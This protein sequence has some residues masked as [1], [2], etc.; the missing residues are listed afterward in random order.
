MAAVAMAPSDPTSIG[1]VVD[2]CLFETVSLDPAPAPVRIELSADTRALVHRI[3]KGSELGALVIMAAAI[4]WLAHRYSGRRTVPLEIPRAVADPE[5]RSTASG[6]V[7]I[8]L[9]IAGL[10]HLGDLLAELQRRIAGAHR[11][12]SADSPGAS[13]LLVMPASMSDHVQASPRHDLCICVELGA[14]ELHAPRGRIPRWFLVDVGERMAEWIGLLADLRRPLDVGDELM[15]RRSLAQIDGFNQT[16]RPLPVG[17]TVL[18]VLALRT[19]ST[20]EAIA[21]RCGARSLSY[22]QLERRARALATRL[23]AQLGVIP[24][25]VVAALDTRSESAIVSLLGI[26]AAGAVYLPV[27]RKTPAASMQRM[28]EESGAVGLVVHAE[29]LEL[30]RERLAVHPHLIVDGPPDETMA[31]APYSPPSP[32]PEDPAYII[33]TSGTTG[34]AKGVRLTHVGLLNTALDHVDRLRV[35]ADDRYLQFMAL[36]FDGF[37]LDVFTTL[38]AGATLVIADDATI[39]DPSRLMRTIEEQ[40]ITLSTI[41]PSYLQLLEPARLSSLRALVSAGEVLGEELARSLAPRL[42]LY[43]GYGPTEATI[44]ATLQ[45]V[46]PERCTPPI[47][48]GRPSANKQIYVVDERLE[49]QPL[50]VVGELCIAGIGVADGYLGEPRPGEAKFVDNPFGAGRLYR[51]GDF[52]AWAP[53][54]GLLFKGRVDS[55]L[56]L[57]GYRIDRREIQAA[58]A[59]H[60]GV[61]SVE[62]VVH[63]PGSPRATLLAFYQPRGPERVEPEALREHLRRVLP[64]YMQPHHLVASEPWP[65]TPHGKTDV[66]ALHE[67]W[68]L[69]AARVATDHVPPSTATERILCEIWGEVLGVSEPGVTASFLALGGDSIRLIQ[70]VHRARERGL[71]LDVG[72]VLREPTIAGLA[73]HLD[74]SARTPVDLQQ[75]HDHLPLGLLELAPAERAVLPPGI[76]DAY[77]AALMQSFMIETYANDHERNGIHLGCAEWRLADPEPCER[78]MCEALQRLYDEHRSLRLSFVRAP[79]GRDLLLV[80]PAAP[81]ALR[82]SDLRGRSRSECEAFFTDE[83]ARQTNERFDPYSRDPLI[84]FHLCRTDEGCSLFI[85]FHH[86]LLDGW[87]GIEL[88]N[89][90]LEHYLDAK[91]GRPPAAPRP[92]VD[93]HREFVALERAVLED[94]VA[95]DYWESR[96]AAPAMRSA[97]DELRLALEAR[98]R[99]P[100]AHRSTQAELPRTLVEACLAHGVRSATSVKA[101]LLSSTAEVVMEALGLERLVVG[102]VTNGRAATLTEPLRSTGLFW[103]IVPL[104]FSRAEASSSSL[105]QARLDEL[106]PFG[107]F[108]W[109]A[110]ADEFAQREL[111]VPMFNFVNFHNTGAG[112]RRLA[113]GVVQSRLC[114]P[115]TLFFKLDETCATPTA[116]LRIGFDQAVFREDDVTAMRSRIYRVL[117][118][119]VGHEP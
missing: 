1:E 114:T 62:V 44:N 115:L 101:L 59:A 45:R 19:R 11:P 32:A 38:C 42:E 86:A 12:A 33:Y 13:D 18:D 5:A 91:E 40:R 58:I 35:T 66:T 99:G 89:R 21:V 85:S 104:V 29:L 48:I 71:G 69:A 51:T 20:P 54:G 61:G 95:R 70:L 77:P 64:E 27:N 56:K 60:A 8:A 28:L 24:G 47:S 31:A 94:P 22:G 17:A 102:T 88:R 53:D 81:L 76:E 82:R 117:S 83:I 107:H 4:G 108:P 109:K 112:A 92:P 111:L 87:S 10:V 74:R 103:N 106:T 41:T 98:R 6:T 37:L 26:L 63:E 2:A 118:T 49:P 57:N 39:A 96:A 116:F 36:S 46:T 30:A 119:A 23:H 90:L 75:P 65:L 113:E 79:S 84:R 72:D 9:E 93:S 34:V 105:V 7:A 110:I 43:N 55:Q 80:L 25:H 97:L 50:G 15:R 14:F 78:S 67:S 3:S 73:A 16:A 68:S 100:S 52:G